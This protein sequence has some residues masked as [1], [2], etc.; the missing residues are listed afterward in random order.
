VTN[1]IIGFVIVIAAFTVRYIVQNL[2]GVQ[3]PSNE[4]LPGF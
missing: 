1:A 3:L 4:V 2:I